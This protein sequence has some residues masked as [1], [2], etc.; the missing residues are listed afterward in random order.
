[1]KE[2]SGF[3]ISWRYVVP[4]EYMESEKKQKK[5]FKII[6]DSIRITKIECPKCNHIETFSKNE[7]W[8]KKT[9]RR[10]AKNI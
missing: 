10:R 9:N 6:R 4:D 7:E 1:M 3:E 2:D 8:Y 5:F